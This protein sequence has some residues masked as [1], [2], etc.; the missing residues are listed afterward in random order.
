[1]NIVFVCT[2][3]TC[4]SAMAEGLLKKMLADKSLKGIEVSSCGTA[5][6]PTFRVPGILLELMKDEGVFMAEH[7]SRQITKE[8]ADHSDLILVM[9]NAHKEYIKHKFPKFMEKLFLLKEYVK[10][11]DKNFEIE[12]PIMQG[13]EVYLKTKE[14]IKNALD[15]LI[16]LLEAR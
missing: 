16:N 6:L 8:I 4:R 1:M 2:G 12:D 9:E 11:D 14:D 5:S 13:K 3:N 10:S 15:K 7:K